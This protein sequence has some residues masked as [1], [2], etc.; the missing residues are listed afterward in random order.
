MQQ[1]RFARPHLSGL[2]CMF[3]GT[4]VNVDLYRILLE[5][6]EIEGKTRLFI[7]IFEKWIVSLLGVVSIS[8][9]W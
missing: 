4:K 9:G 1:G 3:E 8:K 7:S 2:N 6:D 5:N